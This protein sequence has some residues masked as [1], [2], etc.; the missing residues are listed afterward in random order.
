MRPRVRP[1]VY[2]RDTVRLWFHGIP[3]IKSVLYMC[4][5]IKRR[6]FNDILK[7]VLCTSPI[8]IITCRENT[9]CDTITGM[10]VIERIK[11]VGK[12]LPSLLIQ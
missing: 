7:R 2:C 1:D 6:K 4:K 8:F 10:Y 3:L 11:G 9:V 12:V 5:Y